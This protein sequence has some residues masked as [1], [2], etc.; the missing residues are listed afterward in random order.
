MIKNSLEKVKT[1]IDS[2]E[3]IFKKLIKYPGNTTYK[4]NFRKAKL[5]L[6]LDYRRLKAQLYRLHNKKIFSIIKKID[7]DMI[8]LMSSEVR[9]QEKLEIIEVLPSFW[10]D[11]EIELEVSGLPSYDFF[12]K[13]LVKQLGKRFKTEIEDLRLVYGRS[14][15][16]TAFLLRRILE[17]AIFLAFAKYN[18]SHKLRDAQGNFL[19]LES[20][21]G[22]ASNEE[23][24][25]LPFLLPKTMKQI[26]GIK[27]LGDA[28]AHNLLNDVKIETIIPQ[29]PFIITAL[30]ELSARL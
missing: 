19:G 28:A 26:K 18:L 5:T 6:D 15:L 2:L 25:G 12:P 22:I 20:M 29:M 27:F 16:C 23:V 24:G 17:K 14:G 10:H 4:K 7:P 8:T 30:Q 9:P 3:F 13:K 11:I 1:D 21:I